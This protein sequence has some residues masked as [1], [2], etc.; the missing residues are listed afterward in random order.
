MQISY[1]WLKQF[2]NIN[3]SPEELSVILTACGLEV[4]SIET[5]ESLPGGLQGFVVGKVLTCE[6][7]PNADKLRKTTVDIGNGTVLPIVCGAPNVAEGQHV[8]VATVGANA[9]GKD[10]NSFAIEKAK[11]RGE[12][13]EGMICASDELGLGGNHEGI[14]VLPSNIVPGTKAADYFN[15]ENDFVFVIGLTPNR[16]DA[17]SHLGVAR[18][19]YAVLDAQFPNAGPE[20]TKPDVSKFK[21]NN[22]TK[23]VQVL[24]KNKL[25]C[26]RYAGLTISGIEVKTSPEWIQNRLKAIGL[27]PINNI[28]D[29]TNYVL[30]ELGQPLHAFDLEQIKGEQIIVKNCE[31]GTLFT[32]LDGKER[33]L[34]STDLMICNNTEPMAIAGIFGGKN[35]GVTEQTKSV[36]IESAYFAA[37]SI[38]KTSQLHGLKTDASFRYE[39]GTDPEIVIYALKR[40]ALL[41]QEIAGGEISSEIVDFYPEKLNEAYIQMSYKNIRRLIGID[42]PKSMIFS[43]LDSLEIGISNETVDGFI[44][45]VPAYRVDVTREADVIEEILRIYGFNNVPLESN[46]GSAYLSNFPEIGT[47][48]IEKSISNWLTSNGFNEIMTNSLTDPK[49]VTQTDGFDATQNVQILNYLSP[50]LSVMRQTLLFS[51]L[52]AISYNINRK[53]KDLKFFEF[54][55]EYRKLGAGSE[56]KDFEEKNVLGIFI[57][58]ALKNESWSVKSTLS[59][60]H[61]SISIAQNILNQLGISDYNIDTK[62]HPR[63]GQSVVFT[64]N[65]KEFVVLGKVQSKITK[66]MD[67]KQDVFYVEFDMKAL[68]KMTKLTI[69]YQEIPKFPEV[70]RDLSLVMDKNV[71]FAQIASLARKT[72]KRLLKEMNVF[73]VYVGDKIPQN[74][75]AY[76][77]SFNLQDEEQTLTDK[78]IESTMQKL[79]Q[80]FE[81]ELG[82]VVR[83]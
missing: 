9:I 75:K 83:G 8:V 81:K 23:P 6:K 65:T 22:N 10:G 57:T 32:T 31:A 79:I 54:G 71:T 74:K 38:R 68:E 70:R 35:S 77:V 11:I 7:H 2:I 46:L 27:K 76:A 17:A 15:I 14:M 60:L 37:S 24:V 50:E 73:D 48:K 26:P 25:T 39:R 59:D 29:I 33:K 41:I 3:Q 28:V 56:V 55:K 30:H 18:D 66:M 52:E 13:S 80:N 78:Q 51:G 63:L 40:A 47:L 61:N 44:A 49:Y 42:I 43:I 16:V 69:K 58:G 53:N 12:V 64:K 45:T 5:Y 21:V 67:I 20:M 62:S 72:E 36:F 34:N 82:V 4:E 1:N 19:I